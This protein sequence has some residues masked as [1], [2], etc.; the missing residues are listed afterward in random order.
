MLCRCVVMAQRAAGAFPQQQQQQQRSLSVRSRT[1]P[2]D[3]RAVHQVYDINCRRWQRYGS[4]SST[5]R[6]MLGA[7]T[8]SSYLVLQSVLVHSRA[9]RFEKGEGTSVLVPRTDR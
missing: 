6:A 7:A 2:Y 3:M 8:T 4:L 5:C 1:H 9:A